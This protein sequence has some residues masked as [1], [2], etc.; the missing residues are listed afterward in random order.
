[1]ATEVTRYAPDRRLED[2][3]DLARLQMTELVPRDAVAVFVIGAVEKHDVQVWIQAEIARGALYH[4]DCAGL[5]RPERAA[6]LGALAVEPLYAAHEDARQRAEQRPILREPPPPGERKRE[7]PVAERHLRQHVL[8]E[9]RRGGAHATAEARRAEAASFA[10]PGDKA[11]LVAAAT[12]KP[13]EAPAE[14]PTLEVRIELFLCMFGNLDVEGAVVD[15]SVERLYV[16]ANDL[17]EPR[18]LRPVALVNDG[19]RGSSGCGHAAPR[20]HAAGQLATPR[21]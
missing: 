16:V 4:R 3:A 1:V 2:L 11:A 19:F 7:H 17:V 15:G 12:A 21:S 10:A 13:R 18:P 20:P 8:D 6:T 9:L 14:Q 5:G